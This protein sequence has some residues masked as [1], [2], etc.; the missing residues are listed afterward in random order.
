LCEN[1]ALLEFASASNPARAK[2]VSWMKGA[3]GK[4]RDNTVNAGKFRAFIEHSVYPCLGAEA[5]FN[6]G[7]YETA[8]FQLGK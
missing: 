2:C 8:N 7:A 3:Q 4:Q 6:I 5:A 1:I